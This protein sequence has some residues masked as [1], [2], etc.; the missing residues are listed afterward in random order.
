MSIVEIRVPEIGESIT[1]VT[2]NSF[3]VENGD[4]VVLDQPI[5]EFDSD[6]ATLELPA[7]VAGVIQ[8]VVEEGDDLNVGDLLAKIDT[9]ATAAKTATNNNTEEKAK[10]TEPA[11]VKEEV[12]SSSSTSYASGHP[13][14]AAAKLIAE[15]KVDANQ[16]KGSGMDGRITKEDVVQYLANQTKTTPTTS[17]SPESETTVL[18]NSSTTPKG[19]RNSEVKKLSRLRKTISRRLVQ[20][21]N[22]TAMLTTFN[23]VDLTEVI[24]IRKKYKELF[25]E[26]HQIGLGYMSFF[27][28]ACA[29]A[30][31]EYPA[32][33]AYIDVE[34]G[35]IEYHNFVDISI[36]VSTPKGLVVPVMR[37]VEQMSMKDIE[38]TVK[39]L[40]LKGRDG[41]LT[42][43]DMNG[44][45]FTITN[46]G[47]FG[48]LV[49]TPIINAPQSAILGMH[50]IVQRPMVINGEIVARP[51][52]YLALS[53]DHRIIDGK[54]AVTFLVRIKELL[55]EPMKLFLD[56]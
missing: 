11:T 39:K 41:E 24:A 27:S 50:N 49:S 13:S 55:E 23:E 15:N 25:K 19:S 8:F 20:V 18:N 9:A 48:S 12:Q 1:E 51:M 54:D 44:G 33:N 56:I 14:P 46:G 43:E 38:M 16:I 29:M 37:N 17:P 7:E 35:M 22:E 45:T 32:V 28:K 31:M 5:C 36:A 30:L 3:L 26:K 47:I 40:A 53:Y 2:I 21:K 6:K 10:T 52:M 42:L 4:Y 34:A